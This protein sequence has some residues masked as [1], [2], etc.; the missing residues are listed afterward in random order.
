MMTSNDAL[1]KQLNTFVLLISIG[2]IF[3]MGTIMIYNTFSAEIL[4]LDLDK[5]HN[6]SFIK[7]LIYA[8]LGCALASVTWWFGYRTILKYTFPIL[9]LLSCLLVMVLIPGIGQVINGARRWL[10]IAG[11][12]MQPSEFVKYFLPLYYIYSV[13]LDA[14]VLVKFVAFLRL[15]VKLFIPIILILLE[16][17]I[18]T[19][20][21][22]GLTLLIL[23]FITRVRW[24]FWALPAGV[25]L[26]MGGIAATQFSYARARIE[27]YLHP[28]KDILGKGHQPY[29][30]KIAAGSGQIFGKGLGK[31]LQKLNYLPEAQNDYIA[32]IYAEE[33][34]FIGV[35]VLIL[36][37]M[38]L[39]YCGFTIA[40][41]ATDKAGC[42]VAIVVTFLIAIQAFLNLG[43]VSGLLPSKGLN[44]PFFSQG[45]TNLIANFMGVGLLLSVAHERKKQVP[46]YEYIRMV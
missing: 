28:E 36:L 30:A 33:L 35:T 1:V 22:L 46:D 13:L 26:L 18:V 37:Y 21:L 27:V 8:A 19:S 17:D 31:S 23:F 43:V 38:S 4:D 3:S 7:Q 24:R 5:D 32:A 39:T 10:R 6:Q 29:Q 14:I 16:P 12:S 42:Y 20:G 45:G 44:L 34:G 2:I 40:I 15:L 11:I 9:C 25:L 41:Q